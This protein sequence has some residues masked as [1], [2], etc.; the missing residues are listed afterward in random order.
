MKRKKR[1]NPSHW[2]KLDHPHALAVMGDDLQLIS[3]K[4][5]TNPQKKKFK[6]FVAK[7]KRAIGNPTKGKFK[8]WG[9]GK[10]FKTQEGFDNHKHPANYRP[11]RRKYSPKY[12][13][14][15]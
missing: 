15:W 11:K 9:C 13:G 6:A 12:K 14:Q 8:C 4:P 10:V 5:L 3:S 1:S 7:I 2:F